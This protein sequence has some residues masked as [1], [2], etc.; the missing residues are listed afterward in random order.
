MLACMLGGFIVF[1]V[2]GAERIDWIVKSILN[3][4]TI[5][6]LISLGHTIKRRA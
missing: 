1:K 5:A 4:A 3:A 2:T 6:G